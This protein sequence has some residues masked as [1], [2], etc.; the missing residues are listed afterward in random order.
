MGETER[1]GMLP[2]VPYPRRVDLS[3][4]TLVDEPDAGRSGP[5]RKLENADLP[6]QG[7]RISI[8]A[9][10]GVTV[11]AKDEAGFFYAE[12]TLAQL[13]RAFDGSRLPAGTVEDW[14]DIAVRGVMLDVSRTKVPTL[15]TLFGIVDLLSSLKINHL[16]L[17]MEHT[18]AYRSHERV[19]R[20]ADPYGPEDMERLHSYCCERQVEL[21][22]N[23]NTLGHMERW[24]MHADYAPLGV[25]RGVVMSPFGMLVPASTLDPANPD[26]LGLVR[27]LVA[28]LGEVVPGARFHIGLDEPWQL[29]ARRSGEWA[30][31]LR[32]LRGLEELSGREILAWGD[33][34]A[35]HDELMG[36]V[37]EGVT[38]C[39]WGYE[40]NHPFADRSRSL[41]DAGKPHW[42]SPGTSSWMSI[43]G[44]L[45]NAVENCRSAALSACTGAATGILVT[46]WGDF[47]HHQYLP[48]SE[49]GLAA[50]AAFSWCEEANRHL[51]GTAICS[52][53]GPISFGD[54]TG[55]IGEALGILGGLYEK[56]PVQFP[57]MSALV[58][59]VYLPQLPVG[60]G[61]TEGLEPTHLDVVEEDLAMASFALGH[62][63]PNTANGSFAIEELGNAIGLVKVACA[64]A[65][66]RLK[67][68]GKLQDV[69]ERVRRDLASDLHDVVTEHRRVWSLRNR[70]GG[71]D[72][73]CAWLENLER[74]YVTGETDPSWAGPLVQALRSSATPPGTDSA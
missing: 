10:S 62:A 6:P 9:D 13:R 48:V 60:T 34:L 54:R 14:P 55:G 56:V 5:V 41:A 15:E 51:D 39:E 26:S 12:A 59:H 46:D 1:L 74:C 70:Q 2:L 57:N 66:E 4:T 50:A 63:A 30:T 33:V 38:V 37:P 35:V 73:S 58:A 24:L 69:P 27:Q 47:G 29:P 16:E 64:D 7:Y 72:E 49:P 43:V 44:R 68:G 53:L 40:S 17:Y 67:V 65:R 3:S 20:D 52:F 8:R 23:Q 61:L 18:F 32:R 45:A 19:W 31:W 11:E 21:V 36:E 42:L 71:L 28:E 25:E 22:A